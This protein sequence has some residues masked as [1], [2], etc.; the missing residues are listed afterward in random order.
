MGG[1]RGEDHPAATGAHRFYERDGAD[2]RSISFG[3]EL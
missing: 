3:W 1:S 2:W